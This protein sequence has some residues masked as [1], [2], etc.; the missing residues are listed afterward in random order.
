MPSLSSSLRFSR[1]L[2]QGVLTES[3]SLSLARALFPNLTR[4]QS[5]LYPPPPPSHSLFLTPVSLRSACTVAAG[6][7]MR[8]GLDL[9]AADDS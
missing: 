9:A 2:L 5:P 8:E 1:S 6:R 7:G 4:P 3:L